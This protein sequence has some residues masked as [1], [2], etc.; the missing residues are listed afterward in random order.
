MKE[1]IIAV[2]AQYGLEMIAAIIMILI[3]R[4]VIPWLKE[5]KLD[6]DVYRA[7]LCVE[8]LY[9]TGLIQKCDKKATAIKLLQKCGVKVDDKLDVFIEAAVKKLDEAGV[10]FYQELVNSDK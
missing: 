3:A 1:A 9:E 7:I 4:V 2:I 10:T 5:K 8:K 6:D